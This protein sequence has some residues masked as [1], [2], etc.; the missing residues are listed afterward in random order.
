VRPVAGK[1]IRSRVPV[2]IV[3]RARRKIEASAGLRKVQL[4]PATVAR[5]L[6]SLKKGGMGFFAGLA[7]LMRPWPSLSLG[8]RLLLV[9]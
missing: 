3:G 1:E 9:S 5:A 2:K 6:K 4:R 7:C 8:N